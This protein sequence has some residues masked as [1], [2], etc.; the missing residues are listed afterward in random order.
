MNLYQR[1]Q[2]ALQYLSETD[3]PAAQAKALMKGLDEQK[4]TIIATE[5]LKVEG[6]SMTEARLRA[7]ASETYKAHLQSLQDATFDYEAL[8]MKRNT[9]EK[10][11]EMW[12][13]ENANRRQGGQVGDF[14]DQQ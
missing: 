10:I 9:E 1:A 11:F 2:K 6:C 8:N 13:S 3:T 7:E 5:A 12:R 4:K 14:N